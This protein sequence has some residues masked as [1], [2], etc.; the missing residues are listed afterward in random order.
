[1]RQVEALRAAM[2]AGGVTAAARLMNVS[3]PSVS[4]LL[5][6]LEN[7]VG[8]QLFERAN[9]RIKPT[10]E[11][12]LLYEEVQRVF[13][14]LS[15]VA[16]RAEE[17]RQRGTGELRIGCMPSLSSGLLPK[18]VAR[19]CRRF[20]DIH[21]TLL[22]RGSGTVV[23]WVSTG[24]VDV[25][26]ALRPTEVPGVERQVLVTANLVCAVPA[27]H[28]LA[29]RKVITADDLQSIDYI[30]LSD[31]R[32]SWSEIANVLSRAGVSPRRRVETQRAYTAYALVAEGLGVALV[33]PFTAHAF[34][35]RAVVTRPFEPG[36]PLAFYL[37]FPVER[38]KSQIVTEFCNELR[39]YLSEIGGGIDDP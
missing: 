36:I 3:Q 1:M 29:A 12:L 24:H 21:V 11:C 34:A 14:S 19:F 26:I 10:P 15:H 27:C 32:L 9:R 13:S 16:Q 37:F 28:P 35:D 30:G 5:M 2:L 25:G 31:D 39:Q 18:V 8:F 4:R 38:P 17:I 23:E 33:E 7:E 22:S 20:P 6:D